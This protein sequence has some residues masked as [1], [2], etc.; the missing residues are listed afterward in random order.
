MTKTSIARDYRNQYGMEMPTLKLA[1]IMYKENDLLFKDV[2]EA[3]S[4][5]RYIEGKSK[6]NLVKAT[7][8]APERSR[9]PYKLP[10]SHSEDRGA[11]KLPE[12]CNNILFISDLHI[13]Y[14]DIEA[15]TIALDYGVQNKINTVFING[16]LLDFHMLSRF[17]KDPKKRSVKQEFDACKQFLVTLRETFPTA[18]IYWL[19]GNHCIRYE[20]WLKQKAYEVFDDEYYHLE[21]RLRL[22]EQ[23]IT[24]I[25]DKQLVK[26]GKLSVT[27]G[28]H[29]MKGF[30]SP[31]NSARGVYMKAKQSTII[32]HVHKVSTHSETN[33]DG[34][35]I[36]TWSTGSL[37]ELKPDYS[38]LVSN[39]Q[40]GFAHI[41]VEK[42][43]DYTVKNYQ[44][45]K[46][47]LH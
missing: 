13:P 22:N 12:I 5:L 37:C 43:G 25:D 1:R 38:P 42:N 34:D 6:G 10:E 27:H 20:L 35:V 31:V 16:D 24:I 4:N 44:I 15:I 30:F 32:G 45:I 46:G 28:H 2:E 21:Q 8:P 39:Y 11:F 26:I 23:N 7:H 41:T 17:D 29:V 40:H 18:S 36:T 33:M 19:K 3:R 47:K 14:H 9:N